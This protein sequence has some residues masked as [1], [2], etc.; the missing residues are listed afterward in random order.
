M[1]YGY[2]QNSVYMRRTSSLPNDYFEFAALPTINLVSPNIGNVGGQYLTIT[3]T[4]F[5]TNL[6]NNFVSVDGSACSVTSA[7]NSQL[8]CTLGSKDSSSSKL[9]TNSSN[10]RNGYFGGAGVNYARY[11][12]SGIRSMSS[13]VTAVRSSNATALGTPQ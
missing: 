5:S 2:A 6:A 11:S 9:A 12:V 7:S 4:G 10:Q 8:T 1:L 3:G 13:F